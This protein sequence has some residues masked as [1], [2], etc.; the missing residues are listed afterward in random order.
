MVEAEL[1]AGVPEAGAVG[2]RD[3]TKGC[4][5]GQVCPSGLESET[6]DSGGAS[7]GHAVTNCAGSRRGRWPDQPVAPP[8]C[9]PGAAWELAQ[10]EA[11]WTP[12]LDQWCCSTESGQKGPAPG[13]TEDLYTVEGISSSY[14]VTSPL[15][16]KYDQHKGPANHNQD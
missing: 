1:E 14:P 12:A 3:Q 9:R 6:G 16:V 5:W 10:V 4:S 15:L 7:E 13:R 11:I 8:N 2:T